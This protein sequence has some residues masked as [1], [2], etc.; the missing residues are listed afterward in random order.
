MKIE[1]IG[2]GMAGLSAAYALA[3]K[4]E[5]RVWEKE[6]LPCTFA[7]SRNAAI[8]R[9][10]EADPT[11]SILAK[12]SYRLLVEL[13][14]APGTPELLQRTGL[15]INPMEFDYY[16][17]GFLKKY[18][19]L[20]ELK[21]RRASHSLPGGGNFEG[22]LIPGNGVIDIH[23]LQE[24]LIRSAKG[25]GAEFSFNTAVEAFEISS[26]RIVSFHAGG[27]KIELDEDS[28]VIN[29]TG[30]W[31]ASLARENGLWAPPLLAHKRHL[32]YL[33]SATAEPPSPIL[34]DEKRDIYMRPE[35]GGLLATHCD[36]RESVP[37]DFAVREEETEN[38][39][40][41]L[42]GNF[43]HLR[44]YHIS[45]Q[46]ACLRTF[47][48]DTIPV[49]GFDPEIKNLFWNAGWGGRGMTISLAMAQTISDLFEPG[50]E[51]LDPFLNPF[52]PQRFL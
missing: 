10:Y 8:F 15:L 46:W 21:S 47:V 25:R 1:V 20:E 49:T 3:G 9:T 19:H 32:Y 24:F 33:K 48:L 31:A 40:R 43:P 27:K 5:L 35:T 29:A 42:S 2:A 7:S 38:F 12:E 23:A 4:G 13:E 51:S 36:Q 22:L 14:K 6:A 50:E 28:I 45:R 39:L 11:L 26:G 41:A 44:E 37:D 16:E 52:G 18:P 34:W 30:S 17:E